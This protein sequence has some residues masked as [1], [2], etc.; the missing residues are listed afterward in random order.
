[1]M[2]TRLFVLLQIFTLVIAST[3]GT[4]Q[5]AVIGTADH[6]AQQSRADQLIHINALFA[7]DAV[8]QHMADMG[9]NAEDVL[10]RINALSDA[11]LQQLAQN[12]D[13]LP[14]GSGILG[15]LGA[16]FVVL[17]VLELLG[18]SNVFSKL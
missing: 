2:K 7:K 3:V 5:A 13:D 9:V 1:M 4:A 18:L 12:L 14:A 11:E 8:A 6:F 17:L 15:V 10:A 16:L